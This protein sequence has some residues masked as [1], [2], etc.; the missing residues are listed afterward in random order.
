[1]A[2][3]GQDQEAQPVL[4]EQ[5]LD[6]EQGLEKAQGGGELMVGVKLAFCH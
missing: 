5:P 1:M 6:E 4:V 2:L 3:V